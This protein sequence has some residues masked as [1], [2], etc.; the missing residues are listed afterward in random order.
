MRFPA[1]WEGQ[2]TPRPSRGG[3]R[4]GVC[5]FI[6]IVRCSF[7]LL[8]NTNNLSHHTFQARPYLLVLKPDDSYSL[9]TKESCSLLI[10]VKAII[11]RT[12]IQ[13]HA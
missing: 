3:V 13:L 5:N 7:Y 12:A 1:Q 11:M 8:S 2:C 9:L 10:V 6:I 4:G